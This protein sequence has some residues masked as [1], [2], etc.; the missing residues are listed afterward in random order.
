MLDPC[1]A[2]LGD[3]C[4][5]QETTEPPG[6][7]IRHFSGYKI[8][9]LVHVVV[10]PLDRAAIQPELDLVLL[11]HPVDY[12]LGVGLNLREHGFVRGSDLR[13][14]AIAAASGGDAQAEK[15]GRHCVAGGPGP[16]A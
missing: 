2:M 8:T 14:Q 7:L 15:Q 1:A 5:A 12:E 11:Q 4:A 16:A 10:K 6:H 9:L 13:G 3:D